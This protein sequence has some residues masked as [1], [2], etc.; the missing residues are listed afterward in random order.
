[1]TNIHLDNKMTVEEAIRL[2]LNRHERRKYGL[3]SKPAAP[4]TSGAHV[5]FEVKKVAEGLAHVLFEE[6]MR[7]NA[8]YAQFKE[9]HSEMTSAEMEAAFVAHLW[10]QLIEQ[11]RATMAAMLRGPY[12]DAM[13]EQILDILVKDQTLVR[14]RKTGARVIAQAGK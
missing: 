9:Q 12:D 10:P 7:N 11:A 2:G 3:A 14:G 1:M 8:V 5:H 6:M 4:G 13:K